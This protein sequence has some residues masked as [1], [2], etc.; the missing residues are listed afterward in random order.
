MGFMFSFQRVKREFVSV[1]DSST[2]VLVINMNAYP[3]FNII[4]I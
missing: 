4:H 3:C 2:V 1:G